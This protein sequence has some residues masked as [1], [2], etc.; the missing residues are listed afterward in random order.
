MCHSDV[1]FALLFT[2]MFLPE[3]ESPLKELSVANPLR[4]A[5]FS[6]WEMDIG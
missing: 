5:M 4:V 2:G 3:F 1:F 6:K